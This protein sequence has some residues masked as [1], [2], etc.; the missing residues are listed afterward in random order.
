MAYSRTR[1]T[2]SSSVGSSWSESAIAAKSSASRLV[3][4][5]LPGAAD[6]SP[7]RCD[8]T[9]GR[10]GGDH[11]S[12]D[13]G[14]QWPPRS[15]QGDL[16]RPRPGDRSERAREEVPQRL[17]VAHGRGLVVRRGVGHGVAV[18]GPRVHLVGV[19]ET[20]LLQL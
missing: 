13:V 8:Y 2:V 19:A 4:G 20:G 16:T 10:I 15:P 5:V 7:A 3:T 11:R 12:F 14:L 6:G 17:E 9:Q 18:T 1:S